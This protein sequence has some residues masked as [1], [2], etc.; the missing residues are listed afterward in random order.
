[1]KY[2]IASAVF[3]LL[4][5]IIDRITSKRLTE[6]YT[7][8]LLA[9]SKYG[10]TLPAELLYATV[11][12]SRVFTELSLPIPSKDGEEINIGL[13]TVN[14]SG[15]YIICQIY[16]E[17]VIENPNAQMWKHIFNGSCNEFENPFRTQEGARNLIE[18]YAKNA[19]LGAVRAHSLI[20]YTSRS[21]RFTHT[22]SRS[23]V[24][25][26]RLADR[27]SAMDRHGRLTHADVRQMC[28]VLSDISGGIYP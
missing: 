2:F 21:L 16:G 20:V 19:G 14:R 23:I 9:S 17:G 6:R 11:K 7:E 25:A 5:Y 10:D 4:F 26:D 18:Y 15:V 28:R 8:R 27:L 12:R 24:S 13:V 22:L 3:I 1:M